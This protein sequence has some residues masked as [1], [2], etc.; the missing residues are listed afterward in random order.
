[1]AICHNQARRYL[2]KAVRCHCRDGAVH[3]GIVRNVT[4]DGI[5]LQP[6]HGGRS[7]STEGPEPD[8]FTT[9]DRPAAVEGEEVY[10]PLLFLPFLALAALSP[11]AYGGYGYGYGYGYY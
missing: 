2:G 5:Y 1:M 4:Q 8:G 6:L 7:V 10:F 11:L 9:A 3:H